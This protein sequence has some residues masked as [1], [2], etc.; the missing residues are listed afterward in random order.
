V[1]HTHTTYL[2]SFTNTSRIVLGYIEE[3]AHDAGLEVQVNTS[4]H[5][6]RITGQSSFDP[7]WERTTRYL[8]DEFVETDIQRGRTPEQLARHRQAAGSP[9]YHTETEIRIPPQTQTYDSTTQIEI[10]QF[11]ELSRDILVND[12]VGEDQQSDRLNARMSQVAAASILAAEDARILASLD[13]PN[14]PLERVPRPRVGPPLREILLSYVKDHPGLTAT[15]IALAVSRPAASVSSV[16]AKEA[17]QGNV[18]REENQ[19]PRGGWT[20]SPLAPPPPPISI[21]DRLRVNPYK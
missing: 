8:F 17:G 20:Y 9:P 10:P 21:W 19:G 13:D 14:T 2:G 7:T 15:Q 3:M 11:T 18:L 12:L 16:L 5:R 1:D 4:Q 6:F